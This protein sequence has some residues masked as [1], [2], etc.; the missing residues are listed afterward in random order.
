[1]NPAGSKEGKDLMKRQNLHASFEVQSYC[2]WIG[3]FADARAI[4]AR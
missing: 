1:M 3:D 2:L 4:A